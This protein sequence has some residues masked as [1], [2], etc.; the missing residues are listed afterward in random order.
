MQTRK[1]IIPN[2]MSPPQ[3][4][5]DDR[6][7]SWGDLKLAK[8]WC[9]QQKWKTQLKLVLTHSEKKREKKRKKKEKKKLDYKSSLSS[10]LCV[11]APERELVFISSLFSLSRPTDQAAVRIIFLDA[12]AGVWEKF[13]YESKSINLTLSVCEES[14][15]WVKVSTRIRIRFARST[16]RAKNDVYK[17]ERTR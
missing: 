10:V 1:K 11:A 16:K 6:N 14:E 17:V 3:R 2:H 9:E 8:E 4:C 13:F 12:R 7:S 15:E 5:G